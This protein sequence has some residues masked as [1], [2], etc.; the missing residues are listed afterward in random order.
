MSFINHIQEFLEVHNQHIWWPFTPMKLAKPPF[1][2][3]KGEGVYLYGYDVSGRPIKFID[4]ISSWWVSIYGHNRKEFK[5]TI[6]EQL[7][8]LEHVI[9]ASIEHEPALRL[10]RLLAEKT[11]HKLPRVFF[12][13]DGS[14]AMEIAIKMAYQYFQNQGQNDKKTFFVLENGYHGDTFG[15]MSI[16]ARSDFHRM[17]EPLLFEVIQIPMT[18][19]SEE[20]LYSEDIA[21]EELKP[22]FD[23]LEIYF[24]KYHNKVCGIVLEPI[25]QG[26]SGML[27]YHPIILK[28]IRRLCDHYNI[29]MICDEVFTGA[30]R[31][32]TYFSYEHASIYPDIVALSKGLPAGYATFAVTL[33]SEKIYQGFYSDD[34][35]HTLFHGHSMTANPL[36]A[37][38][39]ITS[40]KLYDALNIKNKILEI[41]NW[42]KEFL[43]DL[44]EQF[45]NTN[46]IKITR[47]YGSV[48]AIE[49][50]IAQEKLKTFNLEIIDFS[51]RE[52]A[53]IR[54]LG[55]IL[56]IV[57]PYI[58]SKDELK[59]VYN[60][61]YKI[62]KDKI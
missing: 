10:A 59:H 24:D 23:N 61:I 62:I 46:K 57:P 11:Q 36:G 16:G 29:F 26:A 5:E 20:G 31:T 4:A 56:Y 49:L 55:N 58:I 15:A 18:Y 51:V 33:C 45:Q 35:K 17:F 52:G 7:E 54:P 1:F 8:K 39:C 12:S 40:I 6:A 41:Q 25:I 47:Y 44:K 30:G 28:H 60:V 32:G 27:M 34:K 3:E 48:S 22:L 38:V 42:H 19:S 50:Q 43:K 21:K 14:T 2:I 37:S 9:Y 53:L 13:D